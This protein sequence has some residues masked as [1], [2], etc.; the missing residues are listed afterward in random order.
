[1]KSPE[2]ASRFFAASDFSRECPNDLNFLPPS[3]KKKLLD[4]SLKST[5]NNNLEWAKDAFAEP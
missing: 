4:H 5:E 3:L 2:G 1:M